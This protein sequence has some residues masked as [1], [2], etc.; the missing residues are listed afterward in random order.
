MIVRGGLLP[1]VPMN[2]WVRRTY[3]DPDY[4][5]FE[6]VD[7]A[8]IPFDFDGTP[9]PDGLAD[10]GAGEACGL[11]LRSLLP[12]EFRDV[13]AIASATGSTGRDPTGARLRLFFLL[14]RA[15]EDAELMLWTKGVNWTWKLN[16]DP[17]V[18]GT[19]QPVYTARPTFMHGAIDPVPKDRRVV[20]LGGVKDRVAIDLDFYVNA[21]NR[22]RRTERLATKNNGGDWRSTIDH[23]LGGVDG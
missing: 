20:L 22:Q 1:P 7:R 12:P 4:N 16:L 13:R 23:E 19:V 5:H 17:V 6:A 18:L 10:G 15:I 21:A 9:V 3:A 11:Y 8:W 2:M 14:D